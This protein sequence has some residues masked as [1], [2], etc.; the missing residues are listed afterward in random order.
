MKLTPPCLVSFVVVGAFFVA[1]IV[2][3]IVGWSSQPTNIVPPES[4]YLA[5]YQFFK[6]DTCELA[7]SNPLGPCW[8]GEGEG[9]QG[10]YWHFTCDD[11]FDV[12]EALCGPINSLC[13][14]SACQRP[15][16]W[17]ETANE[18]ITYTGDHYKYTCISLP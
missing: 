8:E 10:Y 6:D 16:N 3:I 12:F 1:F 13:N 15:R 18:C 17:G 5:I 2:A 11:K 4:R 9:Y 7:I 14:V